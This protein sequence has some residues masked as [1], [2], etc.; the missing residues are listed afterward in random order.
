MTSGVASA[1]IALSQS[2][3]APCSNKLV[4]FIGKKLGFA[5]L[6]GVCFYSAVVGGFAD[7]NRF[8]FHWNRNRHSSRIEAQVPSQLPWD[9]AWKSF[10]SSI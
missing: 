7:C 6:L 8:F 4:Y 10:S 2:T 1:E 3:E 5:G 9:N